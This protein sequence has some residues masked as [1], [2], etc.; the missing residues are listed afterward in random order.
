MTT[1]KRAVTYVA[2]LPGP[3]PWT[4]RRFGDLLVCVS[5]EAPPMVLV[6]DVLEPLEPAPNEEGAAE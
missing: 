2:E 3:G 5:P 4:T 1:E 6:A